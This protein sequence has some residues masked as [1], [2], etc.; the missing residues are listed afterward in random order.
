MGKNKRE[1]GSRSPEQE[2]QAEL[3]AE[4][5]E[6][7]EKISTALEDLLKSLTTIKTAEEKLDEEDTIK[8]F[9]NRLLDEQKGDVPNLKLIDQVKAQLMGAYVPHY[10]ALTQAVSGELPERVNKYLAAKDVNLQNLGEKMLKDMGDFLGQKL[11]HNIL[12]NK[13]RISV[14]MGN[15][16]T[17]SNAIKA[18]LNA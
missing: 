11:S 3:T 1:F 14:W 5:K 6:T 9:H 10:T 8:Y 2:I 16:S 17:A 7:L 18:I 13:F 15:I 4:Q 12:E